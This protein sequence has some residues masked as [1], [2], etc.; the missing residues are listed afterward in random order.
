MSCLRYLSPRIIRARDVYSSGAVV[1][2]NGLL[3]GCTEANNI[4]QGLPIRLAGARPLAL[5]GPHDAR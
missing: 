2:H 5:P 1:P 3:A 4:G